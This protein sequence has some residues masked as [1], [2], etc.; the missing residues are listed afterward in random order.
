MLPPESLPI[1][2]GDH[3]AAMIAASPPLLPPGVR[4]KSYGL[5]VCLASSTPR[6]TIRLANNNATS[7][8][9]PGDNSGILARDAFPP[10]RDARG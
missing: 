6:R 5:F 7:G 10:L 3:L 2:S 9:E 4:S 8:L 1:P